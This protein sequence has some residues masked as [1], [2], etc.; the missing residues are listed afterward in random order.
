MHVHTCVCVCVCVCKNTQNMIMC[1][2][3]INNTKIVVLVLP[4]ES[5]YGE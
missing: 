4:A 1:K 2:L 3:M 5:Y